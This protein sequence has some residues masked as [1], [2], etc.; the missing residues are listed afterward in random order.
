MSTLTLNDLKQPRSLITLAIFL[1]VVIGIGSFIG[2]QNVPGTW[3][4]ALTKPPFNPP[5]WVFGPVWFILYVF[6]AIAGWR[7]ALRRPFGMAM[8]VWVLQMVLNWLWSPAFFG[9]ENLWLAFAIIIPMLASIL[10]FIALSWK[11]DRVSAWLFIPYACWVSF[12]SLL[13]LSLI[14][15]N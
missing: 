9:A 7:T 10:A 14:L 3:Y 12:A 6:I 4:D 2:T 15:L 11:R 5:N 13:N 1:I 8:G